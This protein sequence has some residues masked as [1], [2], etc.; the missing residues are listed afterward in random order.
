MT[1]VS[2]VISSSGNFILTVSGDGDWEPPRDSQSEGD[3]ISSGGGCVWVPVSLDEVV[4]S[5]SLTLEEK[6]IWCKYRG[7]LTLGAL[8]RELAKLQ[9]V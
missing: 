3:C 2:M 5:R 9:P 4:C 6:L 8:A 1:L 7:F